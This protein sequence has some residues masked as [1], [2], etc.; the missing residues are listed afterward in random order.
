[1]SQP[2][3][4]GLLGSLRAQVDHELRELAQENLT[5]RRSRYSLARRLLRYTIVNRSIAQILGLYFILL[6][7]V[8]L[9]EWAANRFAPCLLPGYQGAGPRQFLT[10]VGSY[11]ISGQIGVLAIVSVAVGVV[12]LLSQ[13][14]DGSSV[15]TDIRLYYVESYSYEL[16][17]SGV[18]L[19]IVLTLQLFW[20]LQHALHAAG[21]GGPDYSFKLALTLLH[22]LWFSFN[23]LLFL[24]FIS[25]TLRFVE[26]SSR[27]TLRER[28]S[29]NEVIPSDA[30][31][32]LLRTLY[33]QAP[34]QFFGRDEGPNISF[35][36]SMGLDDNSIE[37]II[38]VFSAPTRLVDVRLRPLKWVL[39][40]WKKRSQ[41]PPPRTVQDRNVRSDGQ[42]AILA[43]FDDALEGQRAWVLRRDGLPLTGLEKWIIRKCFSFKST[44]RYHTNMPTPENFLEQLVDK[45]VKQIDD[46]ATTGFRA[47]L[48]EAV[49]YHRFILAAQ[50]SKDDAGNAFNLAEIGGFFSR[51]DQEWVWQYRRAFDAAAEKISSDTFFI[52]RLSHLAERLIPDDAVNYSQRVLQ[53][54]I[55]L[56]THEVVALEGWITKRALIAATA[57]EVGSSAAL[58]G[59]D[60]RAYETVLIGFV[61]SWESLLQRLISSFK[62][63]RR[64]SA[65][66]PSRDWDAFAK[67]YPH[68]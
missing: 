21:L 47:A 38:T 46:L 53:T 50:N 34:L 52:D 17:V 49:Q 37:E 31:K 68:L 57:E 6:L 42:L 64:P 27:E 8:V 1:M 45:M 18:A 3:G 51:P 60:K 24:Q 20:P 14:F 30:K 62:I 54:L 40:H 29:A 35:G 13:R 2:L 15:N 36:H 39:E 44:P 56:G 66:S 58:T 55:Q 32:R 25:T 5:L 11:L 9:C 41:K 59:S 33:F 12:T 61:G 48:A 10:D 26:P 22:A 16:A 28:Y 19:L 63:Q 67:S 4:K 65:I 23:L 7:G 43:N